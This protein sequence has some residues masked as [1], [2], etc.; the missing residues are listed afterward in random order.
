MQTGT[1]AG[2]SQIQ[3]SEM[4]DSALNPS[5]DAFQIVNWVVDPA[6]NQLRHSFPETRI[7]WSHAW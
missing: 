4:A 3:L 5:L 6:L 1:T 7:T 2:S